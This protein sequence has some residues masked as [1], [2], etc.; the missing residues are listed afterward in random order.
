MDDFVINYNFY[1][2]MYNKYHIYLYTTGFTGFID[3]I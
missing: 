1:V 3:L 2:A